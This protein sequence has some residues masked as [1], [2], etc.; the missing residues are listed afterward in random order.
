MKPLFILSTIL[1][2]GIAIS[3][4]L[5]L[6]GNE[7]SFGAYAAPATDSA[8]TGTPIHRRPPAIEPTLQTPA[9]VTPEVTAVGHQREPTAVQLD[10]DVMF[11]TWPFG[12]AEIKRLRQGLDVALPHPSG[13]VLTLTP[14][15][16]RAARRFPT[17]GTLPDA[18]T[19][20]AGDSELLLFT[21]DGQPGLVTVRGDRWF[22]TLRTVQESFFFENH[23]AGT[24]IGNEQQLA[25][26]WVPGLS[27]MRVP[28]D[29]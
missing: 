27:D 17:L 6:R 16:P 21:A 3:F 28:I 4:V 25:Q 7:H 29:D 2:L 9:P 10:P 20:P 26:R 8:A 12:P 11:Q 1:L 24:L 19:R 13:G 14:R 15:T 22:G 18:A 23:G 5:A